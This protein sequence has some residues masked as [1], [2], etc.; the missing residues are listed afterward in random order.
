MYPPTP[1]PQETAA[2]TGVRQWPQCT[3]RVVATALH[4]AKGGFMPQM[5]LS[6]EWAGSHLLQDKGSHQ[7]GNIP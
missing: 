3:Q 4:V 1:Y 7:D 6:A 2:A 5:V